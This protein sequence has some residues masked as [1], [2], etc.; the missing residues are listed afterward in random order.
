[1]DCEGRCPTPLCIDGVG[2]GIDLC[3]ES[4]LLDIGCVGMAVSKMARQGECFD[5][6]MG[7]V[8][9]TR[10]AIFKADAEPGVKDPVTDA[11]TLSLK[12]LDERDFS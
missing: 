4:D 2:G 9:E 12:I 8:V 7:G 3:E 5:E 11:G 10:V 6:D 1:M